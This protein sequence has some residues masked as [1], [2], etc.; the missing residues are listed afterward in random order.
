VKPVPLS[1]ARWLRRWRCSLATLRE[2]SRKNRQDGQPDILSILFILSNLFLGLSSYIRLLTEGATSRLHMWQRWRRSSLRSMRLVNRS[3][4]KD[5]GVDPGRAGERVRGD[6][7]PATAQRCRA[8]RDPA[9]AARCSGW[10]SAARDSCGSSESG[11][12]SER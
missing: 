5:I 4:V 8:D 2:K 6:H 11:G 7:A 3:F 1:N 9:R 10:L 12:M